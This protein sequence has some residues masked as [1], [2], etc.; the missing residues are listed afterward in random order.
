MAMIQGDEFLEKF[1]EL[2]QSPSV[3]SGAKAH[4]IVDVL[5]DLFARSWI[6][7]RHMV[8][9]LGM[10]DGDLCNIFLLW[11]CAF[12]VRCLLGQ[13]APSMNPAKN[14]PRSHEFLQLTSLIFIVRFAFVL[15]PCCAEVFG[16]KFGYI[17]QTKNHGTY[18]IDLIVA[19]FGRIVDLHNFE[20]VV[21]LATMFVDAIMHRVCM[22]K[23]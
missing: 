5:E 1:R 10:S 8:L 19:L 12:H 18:R 13:G 23:Q 14:T 21:S 9:I 11:N 7:C 6:Y 20:F 22:C 15:L 2:L 4:K 3:Q 17:K 16:T